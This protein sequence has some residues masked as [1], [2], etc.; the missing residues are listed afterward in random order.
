M[1]IGSLDIP[2]AVL[3]A[4]MEDVTDISF[5]LICKRLGADIT[6]TEFVNS[7][8]LVRNSR[9]T[10]DKMRFLPEE[11]P[12]GIQIYGGNEGSMQQAAQMAEALVPDVIDINCGCWVKNVVG[13]GAGAG[14]LRD[15]PKMHQLVSLVVKAVQT[16]VTVKTRLGWDVESIRIVDVAKMMED[17]G[18]KALTIHCR[19]RSQGH[20]GQP[21]YSWI[22]K[23]KEAVTIP[24]IVNGGIDS[25]EIAKQVFDETGCDGIMIARGA[26]HNPWIFAEIKSYLS[27]G[28][29]PPPPTLSDRIGIL[30]EHLALS[31]QYKGGRYGVIEFRKHYSGY[32]RGFP[33]AAK[34][35]AEM[36]QYVE[37]A[38]L[39][40]RLQR[41][42]ETLLV[43]SVV[44]DNEMAA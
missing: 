29:I 33:N 20:Q 5:R 14:L 36:M 38:P 18:A 9:K 25:P 13:H 37:H 17:A 8:G 23:V 12:T 26:I 31:V 10:A 22:P 39:V 27:T 30:L 4:P 7:E 2:K 35:R 40:D 11:R 24:I 28:I 6:Y 15:V 43:E 1:K 19:T 44:V 16:P 21:D 41:Y 34:I 42:R 3:L 32:L